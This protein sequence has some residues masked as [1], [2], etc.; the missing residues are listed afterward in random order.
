MVNE[1]FE[2]AKA[3]LA[4]LRQD[5]NFV[6]VMRA[7]GA[8][9]QEK[10]QRLL[11]EAQLLSANTRIQELVMILIK[12]WKLLFPDWARWGVRVSRTSARARP[13]RTRAP[14]GRVIF[15]S[16]VAR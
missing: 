16:R 15:G 10:D 5:S 4:A 11:L 2:E 14:R 3:E 8:H 13:N 1:S 6:A 7:K 9:R 12:S